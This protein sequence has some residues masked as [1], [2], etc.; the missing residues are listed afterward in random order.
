MPATC[1]E[2]E[3]GTNVCTLEDHSC[4]DDKNVITALSDCVYV[5]PPVE[6]CPGELIISKE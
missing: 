1:K 4:P 6:N 2:T 3:K 5:E